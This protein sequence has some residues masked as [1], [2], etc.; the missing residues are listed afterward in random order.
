MRRCNNKFLMRKRL[1]SAGL[2]NLAA[3]LIQ[4]ESDLEEAASR[5]GF[6]LVF[7]PIFGAGSALIAKCG[8]RDA[9]KAHYR[10]FQRVHGR[11]A[12]AFHGDDAH[13]FKTDDGREHLYEPGRTA[14]L[15]AYAEGMEA[16]I[17]CLVYRGEITPFCS[18]KRCW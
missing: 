17:E 15:E 10:L 8:S 12:P 6:P 9:L 1:D 4:N 3:E 14:M 18:R 5:I 11:T 7:K 2:A 13:A 16:T